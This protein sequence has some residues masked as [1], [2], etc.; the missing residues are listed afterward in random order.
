MKPLPTPPAHC[1]E[2]EIKRSFLNSSYRPS[3]R[4][5]LNRETSF[6]P[7]YGH[8]HPAALP[9]T[10]SHTDPAAVGGP[11]AISATSRGTNAES[12]ALTLHVSC[13]LK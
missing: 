2:R 6:I 4:S 10:R 7:P 1:A 13:L 9:A 3:S 12:G 5:R 11:V 8:E